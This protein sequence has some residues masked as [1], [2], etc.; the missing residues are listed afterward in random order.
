[1]KKF[2]QRSIY[3]ILIGLPIAS[4]SINALSWLRFGLD[5]PFFDDWRG[6]ANGQ[7]HSLN[8]RYLFAAINDTMVPV[9]LALDALAQRYL[10]GNSIAYQFISLVVVLGGLLL[11]QW[12][13]LM[14]TLGNKRLAALCFVF[15]LLMLQPGSYWGRE[16]MAYHQALPLLFMLW[17]LSLLLS[18]T[19]KDIWRLPLIS[20]LS[21]LAGFSYI[22]GAFGVLALGISVLLTCLRYHTSSPFQKSLFRGGILLTLSGIFSSTIQYTLSAS[23]RRVDVPL[24]LPTELDF[25]L[26][27]LGKIGRSLALP[28]GSPTFSMAITVSIC[29]LVIILIVNF[30]RRKTCT[31]DEIDVNYR[32]G[33]VFFVITAVVFVY[34]LMVAA[35]RTNL[36]PIEIK[37]VNQIFAYGFN[38]FHFFWATLLWPWLAAALI[39]NWRP[40]SKTIPSQ[41]TPV[42]TALTTTLVA[43]LVLLMIG[44]GVLRHASQY[45][46][47]VFFRLPTI[48]CLENQLQRDEVI[49]CPEFGM[50]DMR[51]A[52][53]YGRTTGASFV[54]HFP[55]LP[56][57]LGSN[58]PK[59]WFRWTEDEARATLINV[60]PAKAN[61]LSMLAKDDSQILFNTGRPLD[62]ANCNLLDISILIQPTQADN[63]KIY[64]RTRGV[65]EFNGQESQQISLTSEKP[66]RLS[67]QLSSLNG[68]ED[69]LRL[70]PVT[71][72]QS[73]RLLELEVR[74]RLSLESKKIK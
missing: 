59:P 65:T 17:S 29:A 12:R 27:Y 6:Y 36:R 34:L 16:N 4:L 68:F 40:L 14:Q 20:V 9:G 37:E 43:V 54:R 53:A 22:S 50:H 19:A 44:A 67:F 25:W 56:V 32:V 70:G 55:I 73:F 23:T 45:K 66:Q 31:K 46:N 47:E 38:R 35:G 48:A 10:D 5:L 7:I 39:V 51:A 26:F 41:K 11:L 60:T 42:E 8:L 2:S 57:S 52:Y 58:E 71:K 28:Q 72:A 15:T 24:A 18:E 69:A 62:M 61:D 13:L 3:W 49:D 30:L 33:L 1:M 21:L 63:A 64:F 74:C